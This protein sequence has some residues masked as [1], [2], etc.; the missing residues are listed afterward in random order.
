MKK[1]AKDKGKGKPIREKHGD[2]TTH[3]HDPS[4]SRGHGFENSGV[5]VPGAGLGKDLFGDN[6]L[7]EAA[8]F[9][10][11]LSDVKDIIDLLDGGFC[12]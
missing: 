1:W 3:W 9:F 10:N 2:G 6:L 4:R 8:D 7:G 11:P 12:Q 5:F